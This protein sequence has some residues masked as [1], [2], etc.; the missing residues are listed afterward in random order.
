MTSLKKTLVLACAVSM[1]GLGAAYAQ[2]DPNAATPAT[3]ATPA[4]PAAAAPDAGM[5][6]MAKPMKKHHRRHHHASKKSMKK[7]M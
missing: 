5:D 3:P 6:T 1:L 7:S 4:S 2:T